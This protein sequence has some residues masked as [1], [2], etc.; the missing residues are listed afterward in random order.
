MKYF[1][2]LF[3]LVLCLLLINY[4]L[5]TESFI[6]SERALR[7]INSQIDYLNYLSNRNNLDSR[8]SSMRD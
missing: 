1:F 2:I 4:K 8:V 3:L 5:S 7:G 6:S